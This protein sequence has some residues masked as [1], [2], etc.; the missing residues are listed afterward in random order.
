MLNRREKKSLLFSCVFLISAN[1]N[2]EINNIKPS[3]LLSDKSTLISQLKPVLSLTTGA[4]ISQLGQFQSFSPLDL[5]NYTYKPSDS[6]TT[7]VLWGGF[8]GSEIKHSPLWGFIAGLGYYQPSSLTTKGT[9][10]QGADLMSDS[11]YNY[12]YQ[13]QS[14][15]LLAEGKLYWVAKEKIQPFLMMGIGAAFNKTSNYQ[16]SIPPFLEFTPVFSNQTQTNFTYA[17]GPGVDLSLSQ[18]FKFGVAYR[19]TDLGSAN[20][21]SA[22]LDENPISNTLNQSHLYASQIIAQVTYIPWIN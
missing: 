19:F 12:R 20:T 4:F 17:I 8:I 9:L 6:N 1:A 16:T 11:T 5:C 2:S 15:Q 22:Q 13:T 21:G 3:P 10:I 7:N 18:S 14:Q